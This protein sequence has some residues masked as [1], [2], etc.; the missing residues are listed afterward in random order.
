METSRRSLLKKSALTV[1]ALS[2]GGRFARAEEPPIM[3][4]DGFVKD[5]HEK[6][7]PDVVS[8]VTAGKAVDL[9]ADKY[10]EIPFYGL[11]NS[12]S[13]RLA[14]PRTSRSDSGG[15]RNMAARPASDSVIPSVRS[16]F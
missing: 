3:A 15:S 12:G 4:P 11:T 1:A 16:R 10:A 7:R 2:V 13:G 6:W 8:L 9:N 5:V 14:S